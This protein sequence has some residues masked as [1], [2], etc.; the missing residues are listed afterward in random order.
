M[1][2]VCVNSEE[3]SHHTGTTCCRNE[4]HFMRMH[5]SYC[6]VKPCN[7]Y[8]KEWLEML[9]SYKVGTANIKKSAAIILC[10]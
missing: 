6:C 9:E 1:E 5:F 2:E 8:F 10:L 4:E 7:L 3:C